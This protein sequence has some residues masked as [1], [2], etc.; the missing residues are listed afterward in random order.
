[1]RFGKT[2]LMVSAVALL[3]VF[4]M[5]PVGYSQVNTNSQDQPVTQAGFETI[6]E[7]N[8]YTIAVQAYLY[9]FPRVEFERTRRILT[10]RA[11]ENQFTHESR[12]L[13]SKDRNVVMPNADTIYSIAFINLSKEPIVLHVPD[14]G[15][16]YF[17]YPFLSADTEVFASIG[18]R[19]L[20]RPGCEAITAP[21]GGDFV[22]VGPNWEGTIPEGL[23]RIDCP[24][25]DLWLIHRPLVMGQ[26]DVPNLMKVK[27]QS[28]LIPLSYY[29]KEASYQ[30]PGVELQ[31]LDPD[32]AKAGTPLVGIKFWEVLGESIKR[33]PIVPDEQGIAAQLARIGLTSEGFNK[34]C[35]SEKELNAII[36]ATYDA[37]DII[38]GSISATSTSGKWYF[39]LSGGVYY[40]AYLNRA[41]V[42]AKGLGKLPPEEALYAIV[43]RDGQDELL[44]GKRKYVLTFEKDQL[45]PVDAFWSIALYGNDYFFVDNPINRYSIGNL[46]EGLKYNSDGSLD[47]YIQHY[48]PGKRLESNWLPAPEGGFYL[49]LRLYLP[50]Q[51]VLAG[52]YIPPT[53]TRV[54]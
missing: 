33:N 47:I 21:H 52:E 53:V 36:S 6:Q 8:V 7:N 35:L 43:A 13:T 9:G 28:K 51:H 10:N 3:F 19:E 24:S 32:V 31:Q 12:L 42:A 44:N 16:R 14:Y 15:D 23:H 49:S 54:N 17:C 25:N 1:M 26:E 39:P 38:Y 41:M 46:T 50:H 18:I 45:P 27:L 5:A 37:K 20:T 48:S 22:L 40:K 11:P 2:T 30:P 34:D 4:L 29:G